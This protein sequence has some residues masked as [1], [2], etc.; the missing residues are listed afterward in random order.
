MPPTTPERK[1]RQR[2][3]DRPAAGSAYGIGRFRRRTEPG[4]RETPPRPGKERNYLRLG[5]AGG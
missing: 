2:P 3:A 5:M 4:R 1:R